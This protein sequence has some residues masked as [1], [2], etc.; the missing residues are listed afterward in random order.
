VLSRIFLRVFSL[1][2]VEPGKPVE[3]SDFKERIEQQFEEFSEKGLRTLGIAYREMGQQR[4][5]RKENEIGMT[6][7]GFLFF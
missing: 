4:I 6:F 1:A 2:E 7:L 5:I 3:I